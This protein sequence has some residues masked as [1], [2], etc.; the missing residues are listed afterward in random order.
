MTTQIVQKQ[1]K[2]IESKYIVSKAV[3]EAFEQ[4]LLTYMVADEFAKSTIT[5]IYFDNADFEII[6]DSIAKR[7][8]REKIRMRLYA[9]A[10]TMDS[11]AFLEIKQKD[12]EGIGY[13]Y[14]LTSTP[15]SVFNYMLSGQA[16]ETINE[17]KVTDILSTLATR[18]GQIEPK[19][20][21]YYD[22]RSYKCKTDRKVRLTV[23]QNLLYRSDDV[24]NFGDKYGQDLLDPNYVIMEIKVPGQQPEWLVQLLEKYEIQQG[25]FSK[26]GT[27]YKLS[28]GWVV[29][30]A[31]GQPAL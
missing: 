19:M 9:A 27:A 20:Y 7:Y 5:N 4:E 31:D 2:R 13:K 29:G 3:F 17:E 15:K 14:R 25:S 11:E 8:G 30:G 6:Q 10:P 28:Q 26:Y 23:D 18:Y 24:A 22:R 12:A 1:F 16:D 21:I